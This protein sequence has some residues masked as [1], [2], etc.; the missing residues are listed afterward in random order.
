MKT[1]N[2]IFFIALSSF[3]LSCDRCKVDPGSEDCYCIEIY[4]PVCGCENKT[5]SNSCH[6]ECNG[7]I[8]YEPGECEIL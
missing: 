3:L 6:A 2:A 8:D 4:D 5:Y 7:V 1:L